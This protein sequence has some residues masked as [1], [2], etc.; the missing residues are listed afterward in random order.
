MCTSGC[1]CFTDSTFS[2]C[3]SVSTSGSR[4]VPQKISPSRSTA[5][6]MFSGLVC[7]GRLRSLGRSSLIVCVTTGMVMRKMISNTSI[8]STSGV[9]LMVE[10]IWSSSSP[11]AAPTC[12]AIAGS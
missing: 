7:V 1:G 12:M 6:T 4:C 11:S 8:T 10:V 9:V 2:R 5:S 3:T